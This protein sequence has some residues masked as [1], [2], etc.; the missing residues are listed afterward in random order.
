[1]RLEDLGIAD[2]V[3]AHDW[4]AHRTTLFAEPSTE[5]M[6]RDEI[7]HR[8]SSIRAEAEMRRRQVELEET[9]DGD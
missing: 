9:P 6:L 5:A 1:M 4:F 8:L 3:A 7:E 2:L